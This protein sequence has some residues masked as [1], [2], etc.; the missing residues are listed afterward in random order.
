MWSRADLGAKKF[1]V[2]FVSGLIPTWRLLSSR[3]MADPIFL[4][5][6]GATDLGNRRQN[7]EDSWWAGRPGGEHRMM[8]PGPSPQQFLAAEGAVVAMVSDGVGGASAGEVAS[9]MAVSLVSEALAHETAQLRDAAAAGPVLAAAMRQAHE[10]VLVKANDPGFNGMGAT[11]SVLC[12]TANGAACWGQAGDSRI[13]VFRAGQLRQ[14]SRDHSPVGRMKQQGV[15]SEEEARRHPSRNQIDLSLGDRLNTFEPDTGV[16]E[17]RAGDVFLLC[18]DG[19][20]DGLWDHEIQRLLSR[21]TR[22]EDL[23]DTVRSLVESAKKASGRDNITAV[24]VLAGPPRAAGWKRLF[25]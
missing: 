19:L 14:I 1:R 15:I 7:N 2:A 12:F 13:Y 6:D 10:A 8:E 11:L 18:S 25:S 3:K 16:E 5:I 23:R 21:L 4:N 22:A 9:S 24:A 20:S 17:V